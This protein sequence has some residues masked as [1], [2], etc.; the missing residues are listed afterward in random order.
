MQELCSVLFKR[1]FDPL[2]DPRQNTT[3][4]QQTTSQP[5]RSYEQPAAPT[6]HK[7]ILQALPAATHVPA[8]YENDGVSNYGQGIYSEDPRTL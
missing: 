7:N 1:Q 6:V 5:V 3:Q 4:Q 8:Q 2:V